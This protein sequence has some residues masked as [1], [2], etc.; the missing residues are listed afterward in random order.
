MLALKGKVMADDRFNRWQG[1][2]ITQLSVAVGLISG[3]SVAGLG[4]GL[5][6]LQK[7]E[8]AIAG[9]FRFVFAASLLLLVIA[10]FCSCATVLSRLIDF[11]LTARRV[12]G[13]PPL[14]L[15]GSD[16]DS[17]STCTWRLFWSGCASF[18]VGASLLVVS[19]GSVYASRLV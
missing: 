12:R 13:K 10:A 15:F 18:F 17:F 7:P 11:R 5:A 8:F 16:P 3:L 2:A 1:L 6:L 14:K 4:A 9:S 19:V